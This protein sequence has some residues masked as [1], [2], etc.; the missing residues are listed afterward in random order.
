[1][2]FQNHAWRFA[3]VLLAFLVVGCSD[4]IAPSG[5]LE[6]G[7]AFQDQPVYT[8]NRL[9]E[10]SSGYPLDALEASLLAFADTIKEESSSVVTLPAEIN[11]GE[12]DASVETLNTTLYQ[13]LDGGELQESVTTFDNGEF[14]T[15][16]NSVSTLYTFSQCEDWSR[17]VD[18]DYDNYT[19]NG[20]IRIF[21]SSRTG[22]RFAGR[23]KTQ[24]WKALSIKGSRLTLTVDGITV[25]DRG[26][27]ACCTHTDHQAQFSYIKKDSDGMLSESL[28][29]RQY[30]YH[31]VDGPAHNNS[32]IEVDASIVDSVSS[33]EAVEVLTVV[34]LESSYN[35]FDQ[36]GESRGYLTGM[37]AENRYINMLL[38]DYGHALF[39]ISAA[40]DKTL[41]YELFRH[42]DVKQLSF[43]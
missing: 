14:L 10:K 12:D 5:T 15:N 32:L 1:M 17:L 13:C 39:S 41:K 24:E 25:G 42:P 9:L 6:E 11:D 36:A 8:I 40:M 21:T 37:G 20:E 27:N 33:G 22:S 34:P 38:T 29:V 23:H 31:R 28:V 18:D 3:R 26:M 2:E 7:I 19:V 4:N 30:D 43:R 16:R 35:F